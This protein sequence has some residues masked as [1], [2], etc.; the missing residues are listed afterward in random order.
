MD[1]ADQGSNVTYRLGKKSMNTKRGW[2]YETLRDTEPGRSD[3]TAV[4][5]TSNRALD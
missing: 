3:K 4:S 5:E 2:K 1:D